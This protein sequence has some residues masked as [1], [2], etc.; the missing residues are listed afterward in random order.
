M[1]LGQDQLQLAGG[2][3]SA[4]GPMTLPT[5]PSMRKDQPLQCGVLAHA[6]HLSTLETE[7]FEF[8]VSLLYVVSSGTARAT[9]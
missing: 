2:G 3:Y 7:L 5:S 9:P 1:Q 6:F 8:E 4:E